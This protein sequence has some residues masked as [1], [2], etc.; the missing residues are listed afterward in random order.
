M[1][2]F[3]GTGNTGHTD[4][5]LNTRWILFFTAASSVDF[6]VFRVT[7]IFIRKGYPDFLEFHIFY[8]LCSGFSA[9]HI[10]V[11]I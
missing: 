3:V 7:R 11:M 6:S 10:V 1:R 2:G 5:A 4:F 8:M 9:K